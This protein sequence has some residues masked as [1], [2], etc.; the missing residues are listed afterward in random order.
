MGP[1]PGR[2][3]DAELFYSPGDCSLAPHIAL[4]EAGAEFEAVLT[5]TRDGSVHKPEYLAVNPKGKVPALLTDEGVL[6]ENPAILGWIARTY[7]PGGL[8][9]PADGF[10]FWDMQAFNMFLSSTVHVAFNHWFKPE[11]WVADP[12]AAPIVKTRAGELIAKHFALIETRF[13]DGR[14]WVHGHHTA[15]DGYLMVFSRWLTAMGAG[16]IN[17]YPGIAAHRARVQA[18]P[19]A[20]RALEREGLQA[21]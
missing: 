7:P 2:K 20:R 10:A 13:A 1:S 3:A 19:A 15:S 17:S 4:E 16:D 18:R 9:A 6:T 14:E 12:A 5:S 8:A 21:I 11:G